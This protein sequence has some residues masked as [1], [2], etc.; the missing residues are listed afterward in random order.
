MNFFVSKI[1]MN[2]TTLGLLTKDFRIFDSP[3][4]I[5]ISSASK[6]DLL[7]IFRAYVSYLIS[8]SVLTISSFNN[9]VSMVFWSMILSCTIMTTPK[10]PWP[11]I[12]LNL[13]MSLNL[14]TLA[15]S[16]RVSEKYCASYNW[17]LVI[18]FVSFIKHY[19][20]LP[21]SIVTWFTL[22]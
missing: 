6:T 3:L 2:Y 14:M 17:Y 16:S 11:R 13:K 9:G 10:V 8:Y 18:S 7:I 1:F 15:S 4:I 21:C 12:P 22:D 5:L 20:T 19:P